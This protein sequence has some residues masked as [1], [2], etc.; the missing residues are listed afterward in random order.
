MKKKKDKNKKQIS[1]KK[2]S[3]KDK[4]LMDKF[5]A[6][7]EKYSDLD[8]QDEDIQDKIN[9]INFSMLEYIQRGK[10]HKKVS[11]TCLEILIDIGIGY[12]EYEV[13]SKLQ[14]EL[15]KRKKHDRK[16]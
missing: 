14:K 16:I 12:E 6:M 15:N 4:E 10:M 11:K 5:V 1:K 9:E 2:I 8:E 3:K 7:H 13:C